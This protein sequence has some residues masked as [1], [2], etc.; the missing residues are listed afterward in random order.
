MPYLYLAE[1]QLSAAAKRMMPAELDIT[2]LYG[3]QDGQETKGKIKAIPPY[4]LSV[5]HK[6]RSIAATNITSGDE[7]RIE[8][9]RGHSVKGI[10]TVLE[11]WR[12]NCLIFR[13]GIE[14]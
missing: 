12:R 6:C 14:N 8:R 1:A 3:T 2:D 9:L 11:K 7:L 4:A 10:R 5:C 13:N